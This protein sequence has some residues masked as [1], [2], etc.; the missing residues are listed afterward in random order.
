MGWEVGVF[1]E[2]NVLSE[3]GVAVYEA[4]ELERK[5]MTCEGRYSLLVDKYYSH[6]ME[7]WFVCSGRDTMSRTPSILARVV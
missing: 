4:L 1:A 5:A 6:A 7:W 3:D 2:L